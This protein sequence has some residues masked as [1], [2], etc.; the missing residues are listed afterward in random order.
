MTSVRLIQNKLINQYCE[1]LDYNKVSHIINIL[2]FFYKEFNEEYPTSA[3]DWLDNQIVFFLDPYYKDFFSKKRQTYIK[4]ISRK[5]SDKEYSSVSLDKIVLELFS[6]T[7]DELILFYENN[8]SDNRDKSKYN[9]KKNNKLNIMKGGGSSNHY[10]LYYINSLSK[11]NNFKKTTFIFNKLNELNKSKV[12]NNFLEKQFTQHEVFID[13]NTP[14]VDI[15]K[16]F[17]FILNSKNSFL[18]NINQK[19]DRYFIEFNINFNKNIVK[20]INQ[21]NINL[22]EF[23]NEIWYYTVNSYNYSFY[24]L[25]NNKLIKISVNFYKYKKNHYITYLNIWYFRENKIDYDN[26]I[27]FNIFNIEESTYKQKIKKYD[28]EVILNSIEEFINNF[29]LKYIL[30]YIKQ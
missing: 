18:D 24:K 13:I 10:M 23:N 21:K 16:L 5:F 29:K 4:N 19:L 3:V 30:K 1:L 14:Y 11:K 26:F 8:K 28:R 22:I 12:Y 25:F 27:S 20:K 2:T 17:I 7:I 15:E 6:W 9:L